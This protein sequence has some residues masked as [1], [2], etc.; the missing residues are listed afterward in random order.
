[1]GFNT[2]AEFIS[3]FLALFV[4]LVLGVIFKHVLRNASENLRHL[5]LIIISVFVLIFEVIKQV[6]H[7]TNHSWKTWY[8]PFHFCSYF[9]VWYGVAL[10][11]RG[12]VR[13]IMYSC[14]LVGG[15]L[16]SLL[17]C[18]APDMILH[19]ATTNIFDSFNHFHTYFYHMAVMAYWI[20]MLMLNLYH[21]QKTHLKPSIVLHGVFFFITIIGAH[22]FQTNYTNVLRSDINIL[23][24]LRYNAGQ[25]TYTAV[26][27]LVGIL[28]ISIVA[29]A[30][31]YIMN[32]LYKEN[33]NKEEITLDK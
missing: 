5:P 17:L 21:P 20:W 10:F 25:F 9:L 1:M 6:Y 12:K 22:V 13:Q 2:E 14:S 3:I 16:V 32:K 26:L 27:F 29:N 11:T 8:I 33:L 19:S 30:S 15:I 18:I 31:Y 28:A 23:E 24:T 7:L 4:I